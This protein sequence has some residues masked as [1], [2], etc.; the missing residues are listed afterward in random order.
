MKKTIIKALVL[1]LVFCLTI[2]I[3]SNIMNQGH[4]NLTMEMA[5]PT[6]PTVAMSR[7]GIDYNLMHGYAEAMAIEYQNDTITVLGDSRETDFVVNTYGSDVSGIR[8]EVRGVEDGRLI[9]RTEVTDYTQNRLTIRGTLTLKDLIE[10]DTEYSLAVVVTADGRDIY[11]YTRAIWTDSSNVDEKLDYVKDFHEKLFDRTQ[12]QELTKYLETNSSLNDNSTFAHV[13]I[14]SS[15]KQ[16]TYGDL[17]LT[18]YGSPIILLRSI[19]SSNAQVLVKYRGYTGSGTDRVYYFLEE[20]FRIRYTTDRIYLLNYERSMEQIPDAT[21]MCTNDKMALGITDENVPMME[22]EDGDTVAFVAAGQLFAYNATQDKLARVFHFYDGDS[23]DDRTIYDAHG[24]KILDID[25]SGAVAFA[26]YGYMN[27]GRHEGE[28]GIELYR[29]DSNLNTIE[30]IVYIPYEKSAAILEAEMDRLLYLNRESHLYLTFENEVFRVDLETREY[31][32]LDNVEQED[33]ISTSEDHRI[34]VTTEEDGRYTSAIVIHNLKTE[35]EVRIEAGS[36]E[37]YRFLG[38]MGEDLIYGVAK[39]S[40]VYLESSGREFFPMYKVIICN[41]RGDSLMEYRV[42]G[43]YVTEATVVD[44]QITL[45][46]VTIDES[47]GH[48]EATD[49]HITTNTVEESGKNTVVVASI[50]IY[51]RYVQI[52]VKAEIDTKKLKVASPKEVVFEGGRS[53]EIRAGGEAIRYYVY[54]AYGIAGIYNLAGNAVNKAVDVAGRGVLDNGTVIWKK[55]NRVTRNQ[56]MAITARTVTEDKNSLAICLDTI[57]EFNGI[58]RNSDYLLG[59]GQ[60]VLEILSN[61]LENAAVLDLT[62]CTLD[63]VL[64]YVNQDIPVLVLL[65]DGN[66]VL[67]TGFNEY[68]VVIMD[69]TDGS[70]AKKGMNDSAEWFTQ[71]GNVFITYANTGE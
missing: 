27:R 56:I 21:E 68:N 57:L 14:H 28:V 29:Y 59:Q 52:R 38:F 66:A 63:S 71:N 26:V 5:Q 48:S 9:E 42:D 15:F 13:D 41:E 10:R 18:E 54:D 12:A 64:Y 40:D 62:G 36:D 39:Q 69:P 23:M 49:D 33:N 47:G 11:Y 51:E 6:F 3:A 8:I 50:D 70:L 67:V 4:E 7:G 32:K 46:R 31:V 43:Y 24:I 20:Y 2:V 19:D 53:L 25:E 65:R 30:E 44:N 61:N 37:S 22:S 17:G 34:L 58:I 45:T 16:I 55:T 60:T 1:V 35:Q